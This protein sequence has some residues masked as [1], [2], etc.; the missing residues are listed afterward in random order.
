MRR[1]MIWMLIV[2]FM[3]GGI[4]HAGP[5]K[6]APHSWDA[7]TALQPG[8][9]ISVLPGNQAGPDRCLMS[10]ADDATL[11]CLAEDSSADVRLVFPRSAVREVWVYELDHGWGKLTWVKAVLV[12]AGL[13]L[14]G[15]CIAANPLCLLPA[16]VVALVIAEGPRA[17]PYPMPMR[18]PAPPRLR[19][20]LVYQTATP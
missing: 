7:V 14:A 15:L 1:R 16:G 13:T 8:V 11:T 20:R 5:A 18:P 3:C 12:G 4:A 17:G 19:R 6:K 10:S 2:V 9:E